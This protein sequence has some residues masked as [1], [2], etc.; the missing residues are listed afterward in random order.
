MCLSLH[1]C[2][3]VLLELIGS[4]VIEWSR[5]QAYHRLI[6]GL[7]SGHGNLKPLCCTM[8]SVPPWYLRYTASET[9]SHWDESRRG[10]LDSRSTPHPVFVMLKSFTSLDPFCTI[11]AST[12]RQPSQKAASE[13]NITFTLQN[14][15][16]LPRL[17]R[18][19]LKYLFGD[20][21]GKRLLKAC[22]NSV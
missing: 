14:L 18:I 19:C 4:R 10:K 6:D 12:P 17:S 2:Q 3:T 5:I 7:N 20:R 15:T 22:F 11:S 9:V 1:F 8:P 21:R 13:Q 16:K